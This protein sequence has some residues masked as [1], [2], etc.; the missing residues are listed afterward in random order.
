MIKVIAVVLLTQLLLSAPVFAN[1]DTANNPAVASQIQIVKSGALPSYK[2]SAEHFTGNAR[3]DPLFTAN[4]TAQYSG[5]Y[6]T[7]EPGARTDWHTHP[8]GQRLII[9]AG[10]GWIQEWGGSVVEVRPGDA[11]WFPPGVKHW[12]GATTTS[13]M[14]HIALSGI[15]E[16]K[17]VQWMEKVSMS[18]F[19]Q[20]QPSG[21]PGLNSPQQGIIAIAAFTA[22]GNP[23]KLKIAL[24]E[25]LDAGLTVNE[26]KEVIVQLYAYAGFPRSLNALN[27]FSAVMDERER[28]GIKDELG[29]EAS[30][31]PEG[32]SSI[33]LGTEIQTQLV[34]A[35]YKARFI[36]F[37]PAMD[38]FLKG[39]L[40]G[41]IFGRDNLDFQNREIAT[42]SALANMTGVNAQ[43]Q[44]HFNVGFN[45]GLT[46]AQLRDLIVVL[47]NKVGK[48][49]AANATEVLNKVVS[50]RKK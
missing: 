2:V 16:G 10:I 6:V 43:L 19:S 5:A 50:S 34:G 37:A 23:D 4:D 29:R 22:N 3:V 39:H 11:V 15:P 32:K 38:Q 47:E 49:E 35:P 13:A 28:K 48:Q 8:A 42:I 36:A 31:L 12:H 40:F 1:N 46:E 33:E 44:S 26:I 24:N 14:T 18:S 20:A 30:P 17:S 45:I 27:T 41:D 9:T 25:G 21:G 7:F